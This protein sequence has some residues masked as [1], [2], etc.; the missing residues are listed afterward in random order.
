VRGPGERKQ[1]RGGETI[2]I[3]AALADDRFE[4][5]GESRTFVRPAENPGLSEFCT[6]LA[7]IRQAQVD[8]APCLRE[9]LAATTME[10]ERQAARPIRELDFLSRGYH[11]RKQSERELSR[12]AIPYPFGPHRSLEHESASR[13]HVKPCGMHQAPRMLGLPLDGTHHRGIDDARNIARTFRVERGR[14]AP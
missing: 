14:R 13:H 5:A 7:T 11:D 12:E 2:E 1:G 4:L 8:R 9:A 6:L 10:L 3:G